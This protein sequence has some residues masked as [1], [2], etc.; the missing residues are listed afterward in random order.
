[1]LILVSLIIII[2]GAALGIYLLFNI[3]DEKLNKLFK[4]FNT[5]Y[6]PDYW[7]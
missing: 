6:P 7:C 4:Y 3:D 1:M 2:L 5:Y